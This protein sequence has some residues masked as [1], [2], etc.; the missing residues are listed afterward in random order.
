MLDVVLAVVS[1]S[2]LALASKASGKPEPG[3]ELRRG[4]ATSSAGELWT[5]RIISSDGTPG[6]GPLH[7]QIMHPPGLWDDATTV[8]SDDELDALAGRLV[9]VI[10]GLGPAID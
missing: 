8:D 10:A 6:L 5:W 3:T 7:G 9:A 4:T 1:L 2:G